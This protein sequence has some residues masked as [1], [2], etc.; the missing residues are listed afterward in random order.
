VFKAADDGRV[1]LIE[2]SR[3]VLRRDAA[4][5]RVEFRA[6]NELFSKAGSRLRSP[7]AWPLRVLPVARTHVGVARSLVRI[8]ASVSESGLAISD[9]ME[10]L[11][12]QSLAF[13]EGRVDLDQVRKARAAL[14][15]GASGS[16]E[17]DEAIADMPTGWVGG[18]LSVP[19]QQARDM[20][21]PIL[22]GVRKAEAALGGLPSILAE[23]GRKRYVVAFSNLSELRG[24][25]GLFGFVTAL[26]A[27]DGDLDLEDLSG[28]PTDIFASP[29]DVGLDFPEWFPEDFREQAAIFQNINMTTDFPTV[30]RFVVQT[31]ERSEGEMDGVIAVD[32]IGISAILGL[33]GPIKLPTWPNQITTDNVAKLAMH[34]VYVSIESNARRELF[35]EQ[36]VRTAFDKL[37]SATIRLSAE[38]A[39][40]F[41][42]AV[43]GGHFRMY[44]DHEQDQAVFDQLG[45]SGSVFR[46]RNATDVLS[47]VSENATG[48]KIDW[49]LRRDIRYT[50]NLDPDKR[51]AIGDL[52]V[53]FRNTAPP[54]GLPDYIIG[55]KIEG[56]QRGASRQ[57]VVLLRPGQNELGGIAVDEKVATLVAEREGD[58]RAYRT[59]VEVPPRAR[60]QLLARSFVPNAFIGRGDER[61]YRLHVLR[62]PVA[63]PDFAEIEIAVPA[64]WETIG[65]NRYLGDLTQDVVLEVRVKRTVAGS[66]FGEPLGVAKRLFSRLF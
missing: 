59:T 64:G 40:V 38:S 17:I 58:F 22:D 6:S 12:E 51:S 16:V 50:V 13:R 32:P 57:I 18:P 56:L 36:L 46:A 1:A 20:L 60:S 3:A 61:V 14:A 39:G 45:A 35:F 27:S 62:Q 21:P 24:A 65:Q 30:G 23:G 29:G 41:D 33:T 2:G 42:Q 31:A 11:P 4:A 55:G 47:V 7:F 54:N 8:G 52:R 9:T 66:W 5:A 37:T 53:T 63:N 28:R 49:F 19:R 25:G 34:D 10:G 44:S 26:E 48:N 15:I 43:R